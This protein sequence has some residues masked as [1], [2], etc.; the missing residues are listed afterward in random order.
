MLA[1]SNN[2]QHAT[3]A[4]T[5]GKF[6][7][8]VRLI[9]VIAKVAV[10]PERTGDNEFS[11][12]VLSTASNDNI[13]QPAG[14][15]GLGENSIIAQVKWNSLTLPSP[16]PPYSHQQVLPPT[17]HAL[18][19]RTLISTSLPKLPQCASQRKQCLSVCLSVSLSRP[20]SCL[21]ACPACPACLLLQ[22]AANLWRNEHRHNPNY[23]LSSSSP[24]SLCRQ[25]YGSSVM[26]KNKVLMHTYNTHTYSYSFNIVL[27]TFWQTLFKWQPKVV[28][29]KK[30]CSEIFCHNVID[31]FKSRP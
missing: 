13:C 28:K 4:H 1:S 2:W 6:S 26:A 20:L 5:P 18:C 14:R 24:S 19:G 30:K 3:P 22:L 23:V 9:A 12:S 17:V 31:K 15:F 21:S 7:N 27:K 25:S 16:P 29:L 11:I 8:M 10:T